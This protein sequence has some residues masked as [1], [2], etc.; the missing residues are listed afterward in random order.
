MEATVDGWP[1]AGLGNFKSSNSGPQ[2]SKIAVK[3]PR[4]EHSKAGTLDRNE[5]QLTAC[6]QDPS[7]LPLN[8]VAMPFL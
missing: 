6:G 2:R 1:L 5:T 4:L 8:S 7:E 3:L